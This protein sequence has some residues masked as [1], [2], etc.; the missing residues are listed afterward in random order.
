[1]KFSCFF[2]FPGV[3]DNKNSGEGLISFRLFCF[4]LYLSIF[5]FLYFMKYCNIVVPV[6]AF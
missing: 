4:H 2:L 1:M 3:K 6:I 5:F